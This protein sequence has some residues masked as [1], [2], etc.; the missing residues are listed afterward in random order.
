MK[1]TINTIQHLYD[2]M[3]LNFRIGISTWL[4]PFG[5]IYDSIE[6]F[7]RL[8]PST[9]FEIIYLSNYDLFAR[10]RERSLDTAIVCDSQVSLQQDI[11]IE[12]F[13]PEDLR[14]FIS[15]KLLESGETGYTLCDSAY[16]AW[17]QPQWAATSQRLSHRHISYEPA[18][19]IHMPNL[20]SA[21]IN[22]ENGCAMAVCDSNFG[23][24][25]C[26]DSGL[27]NVSINMVSSLACVWNKRNENP[28]ILE[29][30][31]T[32]KNDYQK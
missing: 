15:R 25:S 29:F 16:G 23:S 32:L 13:A 9:T 14:L 24:L 2:V 8:H 18:T 4:D 27:H 22:V 5:R 17:S 12:R 30:L 19:V 3:K 20:Q 1:H 21:L 7:I 26:N 6:N 28:L 11:H 10:I 31:D